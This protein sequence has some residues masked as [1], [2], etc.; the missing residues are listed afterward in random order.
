[1][2][3]SYFKPLDDDIPSSSAHVIEDPEEQTQDYTIVGHSVIDP[4]ET[5]LEKEPK[6]KI[7]TEVDE[8]VKSCMEWELKVLNSTCIHYLTIKAIY[9]DYHMPT[10]PFPLLKEE[11][12]LI[13]NK[14]LPDFPTNELG[15]YAQVRIQD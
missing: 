1:M 12:Q 2:E 9:A 4:R 7:Q 8:V 3:P 5:D 13:I 10:L 14:F 11:V 6:L 15:G